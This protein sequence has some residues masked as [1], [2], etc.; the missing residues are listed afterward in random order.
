[1]TGRDHPARERVAVAAAL[2]A[3]QLFFG[4]HYL[5]AKLVLEEIPPRAWAALRVSSAALILFAIAR[6]TGRRLPRARADLG[7]LSLYAL[8]GVVINQLCFVEGL[9]RTTPTHSALI[10]TSIPVFALSFAVLAGRERLTARKLLSVAVAL[11]GV[12]LVIWPFGRTDFSNATLTGDLL[13]LVNSVSFSL[14]LVL[15]R[16]LLVR[17][18]PLGATAVLLGFGSLGILLVAWPAVLAF[19][20]APVSARTWVLA[21]FVVVFATVLTYVLN[22]WALAR[23]PSSTVALFIYVQPVIAASLSA[24]LFGERPAP[25]VMGGAA[26]IFAGVY[27]ALRR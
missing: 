18:D 6:W 23:V 5:A 10:N 15:S 17:T 20:P 14:F 3:V 11:S 21:A 26:L 25:H 24:L 4:L 19:D 2:L 7:R 13:T 1:M 8:F 22:Y 27:L 16:D 9:K 12:M